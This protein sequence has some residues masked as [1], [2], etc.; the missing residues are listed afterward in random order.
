MMPSSQDQD[1]PSSSSS[2]APPVEMSAADV[3]MLLQRYNEL[4]IESQARANENLQLLSNIGDLTNRLNGLSAMFQAQQITTP[5]SIPTGSNSTGNSGAMSKAA[6]L[7]DPEVFDGNP[8]K[9]ET[10]ISDVN[11]RF[12]ATPQYYPNATH[13]VLSVIAWCKAGATR[14]WLCKYHQ[15]N[16]ND[17]WPKI[18]DQLRQYYPEIETVKTSDIE[19]K[20]QVLKQTTSA[21]KYAA[22]FNEY[23]V[24]SDASIPALWRMYKNGLKAKVR[25]ALVSRP[26]NEVDTL[27]KYIAVSILVDAELFEI[28]RHSGSS[29]NDANKNKSQQKG[30]QP[31]RNQNTSN[32]NTSTATT[33]STTVVSSSATPMDIDATKVKHPPLSDAEKARRRKE[34]LCLRCGQPGHFATACPLGSKGNGKGQ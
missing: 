19:R 31:Q 5:I 33:A 4:V 30:K 20:L 22:T 11:D 1:M 24:D 3:Q 29:S 2:N 10:F 9:T 15:Q 14:D 8:A 21:A 16:P 27:D 6:K 7:A 34:G 17:D 18:A 26:K 12:S 13:R 23:R 28:Q 32:T 25:E